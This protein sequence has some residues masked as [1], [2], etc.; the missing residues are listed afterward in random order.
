MKKK[1]SIDRIEDGIAVCY[2][3]ACQKYEFSAEQ[4]G[5]TRTSLFEAT[6]VDGLP[7][8]IVYLEQETL[9]TKQ[10]IKKRLDALFDRNK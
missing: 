2:D 9:K 10:N 6:L 5:L 7:T 4:L 8:D 3:E 1:F